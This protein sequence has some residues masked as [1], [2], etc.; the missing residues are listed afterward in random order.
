MTD[1]YIA[2]HDCPRCGKPVHL[3]ITTWDERGSGREV[4]S[5][6]DYPECGYTL[7]RTLDRAELLSEIRAALD[8]YRGAA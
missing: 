2:P 5:C 6:S 8:A 3:D 7:F 4:E 1:L